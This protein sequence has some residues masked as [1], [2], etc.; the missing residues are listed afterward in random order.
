[1]HCLLC[2]TSMKKQRYTLLVEGIWEAS[3]HS[4]TV[5]SFLM[6]QARPSHFSAERQGEF[7]I[8]TIP[9]QWPQVVFVCQDSEEGHHA[10]LCV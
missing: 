9:F 3:V 10:A 8:Q 7:Q 6:A 2:G 1:M 5:A 4:K